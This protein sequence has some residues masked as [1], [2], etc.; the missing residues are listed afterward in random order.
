MVWMDI[1]VR[2]NDINMGTDYNLKSIHSELHAVFRN[3]L[4]RN[5]TGPSVMCDIYDRFVGDNEMGTDCLGENFNKIIWHINNDFFECYSPNEETRIENYFASYIIW[6]YLIVERIQFVFNVINPDHKNK[7]IRDFIQRNFQT[8]I[9]IKNWAIFVKH[10]KEFFFCHSPTYYFEEDWA[11]LS[12]DNED[13]EY[14]I[15]DYKYIAS[16]YPKNNVQ[17]PK[18]ENNTKVYVIIPDLVELTKEFITEIQKF[19]NLICNNELVVEYLK[20]KT[21]IDDY[22]TQLADKFNG[23]ESEIKNGSGS[24]EMSIGI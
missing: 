13:G 16:N 9:R 10:P 2:K 1:Y 7:M 24:G 18:L 15:M 5:E 11:I 23:N 8:L 3:G 6:L 21:T 4:L 12:V 19:V 14:T 20:N 17:L 22:Y